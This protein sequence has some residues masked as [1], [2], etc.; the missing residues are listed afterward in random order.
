MTSHVT[1]STR[2]EG[3]AALGYRTTFLLSDGMGSVR[4]EASFS[5][6]KVV[7]RGYGPFGMPN[8]ENGL[9]AANGKGYINE[10]YDPETGLQYLHARYYDPHLGRFLSPDTWDPTLP[11]VDIN[12][13][14]Y[15][16][17]DPLNGMDPSGHVTLHDG[18][19]I[20]G[21]KT[22]RTGGEASSSEQKFYAYT[23]S[24]VFGT[25]SQARNS[26]GEKVSVNSHS[27]AINVADSLNKA[28]NLA[29]GF[30]DGGIHRNYALSAFVNQLLAKYVGVPA[31]RSAWETAVFLHTA[32]NPLSIKWNLEISA[33]I[34]QLDPRVSAYGFSNLR[35]E[36]PSGV[37]SG[38]CANNTVASWHSHGNY[39]DKAGVVVGD[40]L[41]DYF[42]SDNFSVYDFKV[43]NNYH[44]T[45]FLSTPSGELLD[46][47]D[48]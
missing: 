13:Y 39:S 5:G 41:F 31:F 20:G 1:G 37:T 18:D 42:N 4:Q 3:S 48:Y 30:G 2:R 16:L 28:A 11:G 7:W 34:F 24:N 46:S 19:K 10:R 47:R 43:Y 21:G 17:N 6:T 33:E 35:V 29:K 15:S 40:K 36:D 8:T 26:L 14:A 12:R 25:F 45:G 22:V 9:S 44:I 23:W 32:L 27:D 38:C